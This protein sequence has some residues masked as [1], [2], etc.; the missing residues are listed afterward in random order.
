MGAARAAGAYIAQR[1]GA[2]QHQGQVAIAQG[3]G[4]H[5]GAVFLPG[6][7]STHGGQGRFRLHQQA[8]GTQAHILCRRH[9]VGYIQPQPAEH[10]QGR[11]IPKLC[12]IVCNHTRKAGTFQR[13]QAAHGIRFH[14]AESSAGQLQQRFAA[15]GL[16]HSV[17]FPDGQ[18]Q[19][20]QLGQ[21]FGTGQLGSGFK[22]GGQLGYHAYFVL[23]V[24]RQGNF[25]CGQGRRFTALLQQL[26]QRFAAHL[27]PGGAGQKS[28]AAL[29]AGKLN[30]GAGE[31]RT[32]GFAQGKKVPG[33]LEEEGANK[34]S[35]TETF[36]AIRVDIDN[37]RWAGVPF[38]LRTG[39]RLPTKCSEVVVYFKTP[40]LNLFRESWQDLPQNKLT[41]RLQPDE[42]V[43]IQVLN[44]VPGLDHKH[45]LQITK[46]DLSYSETFNQ[47]HLADAYERLLLETMRGIQALFVRRDEVEEAWKWVDSITEAWAMDNDAPKPYQAGTWGPVASVA[48]IT[49][50]GRSWNEFE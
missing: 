48:M 35:N 31:R 2:G 7:H 46:L 8:T 19:I 13:S 40:E 3:S 22:T 29:A 6:C 16:Q 42:G 39:K 44:K 17:R 5:R 50:D 45:N 24:F 15:Q 41:I 30:P 38:Y 26:V 10:R 27:I 32:A 21:V 1:A 33:Y 23:G 36:V 28:G 25:L 20:A 9:W 4:G 43:D 47:T 11:G 14:S 12:Q 34:S 49:R 18:D 37:W